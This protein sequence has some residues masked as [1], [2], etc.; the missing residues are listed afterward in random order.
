MSKAVLSGVFL[1]LLLL[2]LLD[3]PV[4]FSRLRRLFRFMVLPLWLPFRL[5]EELDAPQAFSIS[6]LASLAFDTLAVVVEEEEE[7]S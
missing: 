6:L 5:K 7:G 2:L 4:A 1:L 3:L